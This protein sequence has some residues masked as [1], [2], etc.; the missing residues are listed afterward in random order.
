[1][2]TRKRADK[3]NGDSNILEFSFKQLTPVRSFTTARC[4][5]RGRVLP[6]IAY[7]GRLRR[8][9]RVSYEMPSWMSV[10][11]TWGGVGGG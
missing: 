7:T 8:K 1:M 6:R 2:W 3:R 9:I 11:T 4:G 5:E 10:K